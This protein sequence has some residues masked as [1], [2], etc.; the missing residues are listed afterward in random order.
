M[1]R[2]APLSALILALALPVT[3]VASDDPDSSWLPS[4][5]RAQI[6]AEPT[7]PAP[8]IAVPDRPTSRDEWAQLIDETWGEGRPTVDKLDFFH[9]FWDTIDQQF[10]CFQDLDVDWLALREAYRFEVARG[11]SRGRFAAIMS[12]LSLAL[13]EAH[14]DALVKEVAWRTPFE[15]GI[16][17]LRVGAWGWITEFGACLTPLPDGSLL[18]Y[19][20]PDDHPLALEPGDV[21]LGYEGRPWSQLYPELLDYGLPAAGFWGSSPET[22]EHAWLMAAGA[23]WHLFETIDVLRHETGEVVSLETSP[24]A[25][26]GYRLWCT[27]QLDV[28]G[29]VVPDYFQQQIVSW[30]IIEGTRIGYIYGWGWG[31]NAEQEF[32]DAVTALL[33]PEVTD[34]LI[35]DF[36]FNLGGNLSL[37]NAGLALL[38]DHPAATIDFVTRCDPSDHLG[39]CE[40][41]L[42]AQ[43]VIPGD[44]GS[45][46][47]RPIAVLVGPG[48]VSS[49]DQV[50]LRLKFHPNARF[51]GS[52]TNTSFN[53]PAVMHDETDY[54]AQYAVAD[55][56]L[57]TQPGEYLTHDPFPVD[58]AVWLTPDDVAAG[59]DSVVDAAVRWIRESTGGPRRA[60]GRVSP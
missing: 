26:W 30:G 56:Y 34:G 48:A 60:G 43:F 54:Y 4:W 35:I 51:F 44:P 24:M 19:R 25:S 21:V 32:R 53:A 27:E 52:S 45:F 7:L 3:G 20:A 47:D 57:L 42:F 5:F 12:R 2:I 39:L 50:A 8:R 28:P 22:Y 10:P 46:Y 11:V 59:R 36:R 31:W 17:L 6:E 37:S 23:N 41:G 29:V 18:V 14:T 55:A 40:E 58:E 49:G 16:P 9:L 13:M 33:P 15:P 38:F 1:A